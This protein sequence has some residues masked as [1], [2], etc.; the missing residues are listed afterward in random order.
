[1]LCCDVRGGD[2][3]GDNSGV[4]YDMIPGPGLAQAGID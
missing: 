3:G 1:M 2:G 4:D